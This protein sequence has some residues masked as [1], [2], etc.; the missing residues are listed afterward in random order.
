MP[1]ERRIATLVAFAHV[2]QARA[3]DDA[4]E[5]L[6]QVL[7]DRLK[8]ARRGRDEER[9]RTLPDMDEA[10]LTLWQACKVVLNRGCKDDE[11]RMTVFEEVPRELLEV[12]VERIGLLSRPAEEQSFEQLLL[13][14][15]GVRRFLP[16]VL[17]TIPFRASR[18]GRPVLDALDFLRSIEGQK[19]PDMSLAP[20]E[21]MSRSWQAVVLG[22][23]Q[24]D[25]RAYTL[26]ALQRL[27]DGLRRREVY[28]E[29]SE[30]FG[31]PRAKLLHAREWEA[32]RP[33]VLRT[34]ELDRDPQIELRRLQECLEE[35]YQ[36]VAANVPQNASVRVFRDPWAS[37]ASL[38][39]LWTPWRSPKTPSGS[40]P[41]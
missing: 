23:G 13:S 37:T 32:V 2:F 17:R 18:A 4:L 12:A 29:P 30:R 24:I 5:V 22:R 39:R 20:V 3:M 40:D 16:A 33:Q 9:L 15:H 21:G 35:T 27:H 28:V 26:Y 7:A 34:L 19:D 6:D 1:E 31:D 14:Y 25:R 38:S 41:W 11:V 10:A 36:R 8:K